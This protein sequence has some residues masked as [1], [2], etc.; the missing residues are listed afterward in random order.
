MTTPEALRTALDAA[1]PPVQFAMAYGSGVFAQK[2]HDASTSMIDLVFAV[3]DPKQWHAA[4][5][6]RNAGHYSFLKW[7]GA[8]TITAV[9]ENYG[10]GLYYNTLVP[11]LNPAVGNR[12]IKYGVVSTKTL[13][14]DLTAWKTLY[15]SGRMHKPVSILSATDGIHAA[16]AQNLAHAVH[17]ALLCLPEKFSRMDLFMKIA[18]ISYLGDFRMTFGENPRKVRN[19]VEANY[20]AFQEL[21]QS[22][23]QN[24]PFLS[25]SLSDND[26]LV[27]N[28]VSPTVHTELLDSLPANVARRVGSAERLADRKV[29]KKSVQRAVASVVNRYSRSQSIKGIVTAG[30]VKS[31]VYVAQKLQRTYFKR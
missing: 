6:E 14:E 10:A 28:A 30:A 13:C 26:I 2:N 20:P 7:F 11:L 18:G 25:P 1:F 12:L 19:I 9:Q 3:D 5:L 24:S 15:L 4:N 22:H 27:S 21:Y 16:S 23:L 17:Y 31:V 29:A 8:D